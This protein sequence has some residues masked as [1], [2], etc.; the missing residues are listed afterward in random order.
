MSNKKLYTIEPAD[1]NG[2]WIIP[3]GSRDPQEWEWIPDAEDIARGENNDLKKEL[4]DARD[5]LESISQLT[6]IWRPTGNDPATVMTAV[7][8]RRE[9][10]K[11]DLV[12]RREAEAELELLS[13]TN[14]QL[15]EA[16]EAVGIGSESTMKEM[17]MW[18]R[19]AR[20]AENE[21]NDLRRQLREATEWRSMES[22]PKD[23]MPYLFSP[24]RGEWCPIPGVNY[25]EE[26][27][28]E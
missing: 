28:D 24:E 25:G 4:S 10:W 15:R 22:A 18:I 19:R 14:R 21:I 20:D 16:V 8:M 23:G 3:E 5:A 1:P 11:E 9:A 13:K 6:G 2:R 17:K 26:K 7:A 27:S 12:R